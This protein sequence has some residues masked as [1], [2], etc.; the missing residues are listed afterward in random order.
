M[1]KNKN[2]KKKNKQQKK[3]IRKR[4]R[5]IRKRRI[6]NWNLL[7]AREQL[8]KIQNGP[9]WVSWPPLVSSPAWLPECHRPGGDCPPPVLRPPPAESWPA[10]RGSCRPSHCRWRRETP[11]S[12]SAVRSW[13]R[14][15]N[16]PVWLKEEDNSVIVALQ[17]CKK[18]RTKNGFLCNNFDRII[19]IDSF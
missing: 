12:W 2:K 19:I 1:K 13:S 15:W 6:L 5:W 17:I 7:L 16:L 4:R 18:P 10:G 9:R 11:I 8:G 14:S 3:K